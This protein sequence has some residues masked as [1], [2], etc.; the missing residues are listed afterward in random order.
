M[1]ADFLQGTGKAG[2]A[3]SSGCNETRVVRVRGPSY[4]SLTKRSPEERIRTILGH[5]AGF[6]LPPV[7]SASLWRYF[8][9]LTSRLTF[10]F[11]ARRYSESEHV[12]YPV[13]VVAL[14]DPRTGS[15][16]PAGLFCEIYLKDK[17]DVLPL[18]DIEVGDD[19]PNF[20]II[21]DYWYWV[22]NRC[23]SPSDVP[24]GRKR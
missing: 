12:V 13:T 4:E 10:P 19:S 2:E 5:P 21:E 16:V 17:R 23:E 3:F 6:L 15:D 18:V 14:V 1:T 11:E 20:S 7:N 8:E 24:S 9:Y 22:W